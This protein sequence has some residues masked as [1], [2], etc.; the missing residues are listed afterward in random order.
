MFQLFAIIIVGIAHAA[1]RGY[2]L[3]VSGF[4]AL[5]ARETIAIALGPIAIVLLAQ[6]S[7]VCFALRP[8]GLRGVIIAERALLIAQWAILISF[9]AATLAFGWHRLVQRWLG[10]DVVLFDLLFTIA[11]PLAGLFLTWIVHHPAMRRLRDSITLRAADEGRAVHTPPGRLR[12]AFLQ[13]RLNVLFMLVPLL[14]I[15][16]WSDCIDLWLPVDDTV[17]PASALLAEGLTFAGA[18]VVFAFA[19]VIARLILDLHPLAPGE[20]RDDLLQICRDHRVRVRDILLWRT[21]GAMIN[22]AVM[23]IIGRLRYVM[24]TDA[25]LESMRREQVIAVMAHEIGHVRR[26][27]IPWLI[28]ALMAAILLPSFVAD[29]ILH[30]LAVWDMIDVPPEWWIDA[31]GMSLIALVAI[32]TFGWISRRFERQADAFAVQ[33]LS[34]LREAKDQPDSGDAIRPEAATA[35]NSALEIVSR[36]NGINPE[37]RSW[38][39]GSIRWRQHYLASLVGRSLRGLSIDRA[40]R[41]VKVMVAIVLL[42][43]LPLVVRDIITMAE[44][45]QQENAQ[46]ARRAEW[47]RTFDEWTGGRIQD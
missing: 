25:L 45:Q 28:G 8:P 3:Q 23:G 27:H 46:A 40:V 19:P 30:A 26:H 32:F 22:G 21:D 34:G 31:T 42:G 24:L 12:Y 17:T 5:S 29:W 9:A 38:R 20:V 11:P 47:R 44:I 33:H 15:V 43:L 7:V 13:L 41:A 6:W 36:L 16:T 1:D 35:M 10:G 2:V 4:P 18:I 39:H 14:L 37:R